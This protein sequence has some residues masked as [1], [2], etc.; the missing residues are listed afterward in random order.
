MD[1]SLK[2]EL[3]QYLKDY[4]CSITGEEVSNGK[5]FLCLSKEHSDTMPSMVYYE[6]PTPKFI[7]MG[8]GKSFDIF[9]V[10]RELEGLQLNQAISK[11]AIKYGLEDQIYKNTIKPTEIKAVLKEFMNIALSFKEELISDNVKQ[12][13][14]LKHITASDMI[15]YDIGYIRN[16]TKV[17]E[18]LSKKYGKNTLF[19]IGL[20]AYKDTEHMFIGKDFLIFGIKDQN[21]EF[22]SVASRYCGTNEKVPKY[23]NIKTSNKD[24]Y[25][26]ADMPYGINIA[27]NSKY[28][29]ELIIVEG[30]SDA[31]ALYKNGIENCIALSG[32]TF[33]KE[34]FEVIK[35]LDYDSI[36]LSLDND[37]AGNKAV[38]QIIDFCNTN[39]YKLNI[40]SKAF[41]QQLDPDE[42]II[43]YGIEKYTSLPLL[44]ETKIVTNFFLNA[45]QGYEALKKI[46]EFLYTKKNFSLLS[47]VDDIYDVFYERGIVLNKEKLFNFVE[48]KLLE[49]NLEDTIIDMSTI[50]RL[51]EKTENNCLFLTNKML[52]L[53]TDVYDVFVKK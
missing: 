52:S 16:S 42:Y 28:K 5:K 44:S 18:L 23:I 38:F 15:K 20:L 48:S 24:F 10:A 2:N 50:K 17:L 26:K 43:K 36:V 37:K 53:R 11:L 27:K 22:V 21:N 29:N 1:D 46:G 31:I 39:G 49:R 47:T 45:M 13:L 8:C 32:L 40:F 30:Y 7:C 12:Y 33:K 34:T 6:N 35:S 25:N 3:K 9:D 41:D 14:D 4:Y 51:L 19:E